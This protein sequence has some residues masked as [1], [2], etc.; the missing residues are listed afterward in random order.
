MSANR[1]AAIA[2]SC[3]STRAISVCSIAP[4]LSLVF[5][6][7]SIAGFQSGFEPFKQSNDLR[8]PGLLF[9]LD[10]LQMQGVSAVTLNS[11]LLRWG[12]VLS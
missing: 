3:I 7:V 4:K 10:L 6:F 1:I 2:Q 5:F 9:L 11:R 8:G 12:R